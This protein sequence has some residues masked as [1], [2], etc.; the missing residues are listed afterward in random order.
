VFQKSLYFSENF[1]FYNATLLTFAMKNNNL[2]QLATPLLRQLLHELLLH[3]NNEHGIAA[4]MV[5][6]QLQLKALS[7]MRNAMSYN[8]KSY[9]Q[10]AAL[11]NINAITQHYQIDV[12]IGFQNNTAYFTFI[13]LIAPQINTAPTTFIY[14]YY[15]Y[16]SVYEQ[17]MQ[18]KWVVSPDYKQAELFFYNLEKQLVHRLPPAKISQIGHNLFVQMHN[19]NNNSQ[20]SLLILH[21]ANYEPQKL[22]FLV[23][24]YSSV[25]Q[26]DSKPI[27]GRVVIQKMES[28]EA[29]IQ[30]L[31]QDVPLPIQQYLHQQQCTGA[32]KVFFSV[33]EFKQ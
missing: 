19:S 13:P 22:S 16:S 6:Q 1:Q 18:S 27:S 11:A 23:G 12:Q 29:F 8:G 3:L 9:N 24:V 30:C 10:V 2:D 25:R 4:R 26:R 15:Y 32:N 5:E 20:P 7:K 21:T 31:N 33:N 17:V 14:L 28:E